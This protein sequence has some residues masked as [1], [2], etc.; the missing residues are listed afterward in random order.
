MLTP[1]HL[2]DLPTRGVSLMPP[3]TI[4]LSLWPFKQS[5]L[6]HTSYL[7]ASLCGALL[8]LSQQADDIQTFQGDIYPP[9]P[10]PPFTLHCPGSDSLLLPP[11]QTSVPFLPPA[12]AD[13]LF[14]RCLGHLHSG[15]WAST[16]SLAYLPIS[17]KTLSGS[18][19]IL[20]H[21]LSEVLLPSANLTHPYSGSLS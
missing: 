14:L 15:F 19:Q 9:P 16:Y 10:N 7:S 20:I 18:L 12:A 13:L 1:G 17:F 3:H 5:I 2:P 11:K 6:K 8:P 21:S 4:H